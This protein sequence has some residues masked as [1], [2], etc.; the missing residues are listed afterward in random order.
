M[1]MACRECPDFCS[2]VLTDAAEAK[3]MHI[4]WPD[5]SGQDGFGGNL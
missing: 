2:R 3:Y 4:H 1:G 5:I